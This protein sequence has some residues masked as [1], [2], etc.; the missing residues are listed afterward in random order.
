MPRPRSR[1]VLV[2]ALVALITVLAVTTAEASAHAILQASS[3]ADGAHLDT[4]PASVS[5]TFNEPVSASLGSV[6]V[7]DGGGNR[8]DQG[9][10]LARD[11]TVSVGLKPGL[12]D[13][14]YVVTWRVISADSHT[15]RGAFTFTVGAGS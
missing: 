5:M 11:T 1:H 14:G 15:V 7:F 13:G 9:D 8:V 12:G 3:P 2:V 4:A 6:R 10:V